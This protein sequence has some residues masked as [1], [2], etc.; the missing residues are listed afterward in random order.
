M[1]TTGSHGDAPPNGHPRSLP[2]PSPRWSNSHPRQRNRANVSLR[3]KVR[4]PLAALTNGTVRRNA[5]CCAGSRKASSPARRAP[6]QSPT[7]WQSLGPKI[8][9]TR[10]LLH[11]RQDHDRCLIHQSAG[12]R[13]AASRR[14]A[15]IDF[16]RYCLGVS[17]MCAPTDRDRAK[18]TGSS[19]V[20]T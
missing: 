20:L 9:Q 4:R 3:D 13:V 10:S 12:K 5:K 18:R 8:L 1:S 6:C 16:P 11:P 2:A 14:P 15:A 17:P 19:I 7:A